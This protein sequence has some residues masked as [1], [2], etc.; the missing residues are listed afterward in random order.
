[1]IS[2][3]ESINGWHWLSFGF[4]LLLGELLGVGG[5]FLWIGLGACGV[6]ILLFFSD[7]GWELQWVLFS[8]QL[9]LF[10]WLWWKYQHRQ[11]MQ[12]D[13]VSTLN[14]RNQQYVGRRFRLMLDSQTGT[15]HVRIDDTL[16]PVDVDEKCIDS[17]WIDGEWVEITGADGIRLQ[18]RRCQQ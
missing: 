9:L 1:M 4:V 15:A 12:H 3:L 7:I 8:V 5:Y 13:L 17:E 18:I 6:G 10:S 16:W 14:R 2:F 11:D